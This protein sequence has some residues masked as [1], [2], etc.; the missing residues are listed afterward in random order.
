MKS[1]TRFHHSLLSA[2]GKDLILLGNVDYDPINRVY[3]I[4]RSGLDDLETRELVDIL[5]KSSHLILDSVGGMSVYSD[6]DLIIKTSIAYSYPIV[7]SSSLGYFTRIIHKY[8]ILHT[9]HKPTRNLFLNAR[10]LTG[11][12]SLD[13]I[14][15]G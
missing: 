5:D 3:R 2:R 15:E 8:F 4:S 11:E 12:K 13:G 14:V 6:E 7:R 1:E 10:T 9:I